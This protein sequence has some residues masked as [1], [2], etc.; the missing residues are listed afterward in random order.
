MKRDPCAGDRRRARAAICLNDIAIKRDLSLGELAKINDRFEL[1]L[2]E[3]TQGLEH[4][5]PIG[6]GIH[7]QGTMM[8]ALETTPFSIA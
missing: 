2:D 1:H 4:E 5:G 7:G 8:L 6:S 3:S